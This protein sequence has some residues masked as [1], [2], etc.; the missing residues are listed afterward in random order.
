LFAQALQDY[1]QKQADTFSSASEE[2]QRLNQEL[3]SKNKQLLEATRQSLDLANKQ[4]GDY[5]AMLAKAEE[6]W[7]AKLQSLQDVYAG[8]DERL[9]HQ[10]RGWLG[11]WVGGA[12]LRPQ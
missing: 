3:D 5:E 12:E 1:I 11:G 9:K 8:I 4:K 2:Q 10:V 7:R 6:E